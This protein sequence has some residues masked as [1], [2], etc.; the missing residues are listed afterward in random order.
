M[1]GQIIKT[2]ARH[3]FSRSSGNS[4]NPYLGLLLKVSKI[5]KKY[6]SIFK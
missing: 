4:D 3:H 5:W 1:G 2:R 6:F